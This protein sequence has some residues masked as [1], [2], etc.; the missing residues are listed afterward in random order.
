MKK[1]DMR[2]SKL[3]G[4]AALVENFYK[5]LLE[6]STTGYACHKIVCDEEG[7]PCDYEIMEVNTVVEILTGLRRKT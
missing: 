1:T 6:E 3:G 2:N 5:Q 7:I 4:D